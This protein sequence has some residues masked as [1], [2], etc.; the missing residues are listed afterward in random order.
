MTR[1]SPTHH[2]SI[3]T[4]TSYA[5]GSLRAGFDVVAAAHIANCPHCRAELPLLESVGGLVLEQSDAVDVAPD[6]LARAI[7]QLDQPV[8]PMGGHKSL[9]A[10]LA[11]AKRRWVAPGVWVANVATPHATED[12]V[13][14]LSVAPG[15]ATA[16]HT[17][18]GLEF[19]HVISGALIDDGVIY[20]A[21]D[22]TERDTQHVHRPLAHG[23]EPC[24]CLF[25]TQGRLVASGWVGRL[26]FAF[27]NV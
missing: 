20:R 8:A 14:M 13:Y 7:S 24:V 19:T 15:A 25:A 27:A 6:A 11:S 12:R 16:Q 23:D 18:S 2:P 26:A 1:V 10:L 3:E 17:H 22:F 21:G 5:A 4:L 9:K